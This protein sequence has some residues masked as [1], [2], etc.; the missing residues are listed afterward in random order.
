M[1]ADARLRLFLTIQ[2]LDL[3]GP[4]RK[5]FLRIGADPR[6]EGPGDSHS[7]AYV[8]LFFFFFLSFFAAFFASRLTPYQG[9]RRWLS[10][11]FCLQTLF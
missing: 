8:S 3:K 6:V 10:S 11:R 4:V 2:V 7:F 5:C 9:R 1:I